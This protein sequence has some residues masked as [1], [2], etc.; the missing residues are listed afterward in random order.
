[1]LHAAYSIGFPGCKIREIPK[2]I[3]I[4]KEREFIIKECNRKEL[5]LLQVSLVPAQIT[6]V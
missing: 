3:A 6:D 2:W 4:K 5:V 1:M